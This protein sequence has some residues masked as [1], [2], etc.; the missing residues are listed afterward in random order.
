MP[1]GVSHRV[2]SIFNEFR[3][4]QTYESNVPVVSEK[5]TSSNAAGLNDAQHALDRNP[6][7]VRELG[8]DGDLMNAVA[9]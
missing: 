9:Q 1:P 8:I 6:R 4:C 7:S 5:T 2:T 3:V